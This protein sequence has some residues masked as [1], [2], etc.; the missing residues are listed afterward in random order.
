MAE[1][2]RSILYL[3]A[4]GYCGWTAKISYDEYIKTQDNKVL[5]ALVGFSL[6][7]ILIA[8]L[9]YRE[10]RRVKAAKEEE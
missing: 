9:S 1:Y 6:A 10:Y 3:F 4:A 7:A 5:I 8:F 2:F